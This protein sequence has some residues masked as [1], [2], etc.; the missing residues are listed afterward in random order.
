MKKQQVLQI[1]RFLSGYL[2]MIFLYIIKYY[3]YKNFLGFKSKVWHFILCALLVIVID[4]YM[5]KTLP[6]LSIIII[7]NIIW[8]LIICFLCNGNFLMKFYAVILEE[9]AL[10]LINLSFLSFD[11]TILPTIHNINVSF[12]KHIII[13][14]MINIINDLIRYTILF[15]FLKNIC[16]FLNLKE[17]SIKLYENLFLLIPC[18]SIYCLGLIFYIIQPINIDNKRYYLPYIFPKIYYTLPFISFS[19]LLSLLIMAYTF[20]KMIEGQLEEEKS[21]LMEQQFKLQLTHSHN[22]E[23]LYKGIRVII[24]DMNNHVSCLKNLA[25]TNNIEDIKKYLININET[26]SKLD[27]KIKT[28]NSISDAVINEKYNIARTNKIEFICDLLL[29]KETILEPVDLCVILSNT[30]DNAL[31]ACMKITDNNL[32]KKICIKSYIKN[33][34]LIIEV[35]NSTKDKIQYSKNKIVSSKN[36]KNNHGIGISNIETVA[37]KYNGTIDILEEKHKFIINIMLKIK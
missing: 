29:P 16:K 33:M 25:A 34:Y 32:P 30:L 15:I 11:F 10:L 35:S 7:N 22:I 2:T 36:D 20:K 13:S 6:L 21:L 18:L 3:F 27:F 1:S 23:M 17:K 24:H 31:E 19:L 12:N 8:L 5:M 4:F 9:T 26:I 37:K 28:G 14:S